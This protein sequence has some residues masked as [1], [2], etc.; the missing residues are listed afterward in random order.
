MEL[1]FVVAAIEASTDYSDELETFDSK[2][3]YTY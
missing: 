1:Y 2:G 3:I